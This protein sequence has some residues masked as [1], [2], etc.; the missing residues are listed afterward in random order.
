MLCQTGALI[1]IGPLL[2]IIADKKGPLN[3]LRITALGLMIPELL[4]AFFTK[5]S[6]IFISSFAIAILALVSTIVSYAPFVME[7]YGIEESVILEGIM[8]VFAKLSEVTTTV[9]AFVVSFFY[10][11][12]EI[13]KPY[14]LMYLIGAG[15]CLLSFILLMFEKKEKFDYSDKEEDLGTLVDK[16]RITEVN[17]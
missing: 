13:V 12:E 9:T 6:V 7:V 17:V 5:I 3:L 4:L 14:K 1:L 15:V 2:G 16:D 8:G 10:S 11:K